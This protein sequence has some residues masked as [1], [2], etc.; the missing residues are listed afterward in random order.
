MICPPCRHDM[1]DMTHLI[2]CVSYTAGPVCYE[3]WLQMLHA[4]DQ[5]YVTSHKSNSATRF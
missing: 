2:Y 3:N 5:E 4:R 1:V